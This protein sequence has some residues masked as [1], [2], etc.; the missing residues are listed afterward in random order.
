MVISLFCLF[1]DI[2]RL[3]FNNIKIVL[4]FLKTWG[5]IYRNR[6][7]FSVSFRDFQISYRIESYR[8][9]SKSNHILSVF[10]IDFS[11]STMPTCHRW[12]W[13]RKCEQY[14]AKRTKLGLSFLTLEVVVC[15]AC[16]CTVKHY[17]QNWMWKLG[18]KPS[19][20]FPTRYYFIPC[21]KV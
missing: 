17:G 3:Y 5:K 10:C 8:I 9:K 16:P 21:K 6:I 20:F 11:I 13:W 7:I 1:V 2:K 15:M 14:L 19:R 12:H 4:I 18:L